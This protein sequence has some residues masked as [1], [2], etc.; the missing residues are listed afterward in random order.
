MLDV[1]HHAVYG[2]YEPIGLLLDGVASTWATAGGLPTVDYAP[3][4]P[5]R[6]RQTRTAS[7]DDTD[8]ARFLLESAGRDVDLMLEIK[9]KEASAFRAPA[10]A[11]GDPRL[12]IEP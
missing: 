6:R 10:L 2:D 3:Q 7:L 9:D 1:L 11:A 8:F 12:R 4:A 5:G